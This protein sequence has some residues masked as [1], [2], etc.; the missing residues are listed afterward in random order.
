MLGTQPVQAI[1]VWSTPSAAEW[2]EIQVI[3]A[4]IFV[5]LEHLQSKWHDQLAE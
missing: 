1:P 2:S 3:A 5:L 4:K